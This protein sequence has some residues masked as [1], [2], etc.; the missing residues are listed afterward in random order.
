AAAPHKGRT[1]A[2]NRSRRGRTRMTGLCCHSREC[3]YRIHTSLIP[4]CFQEAADSLRVPLLREAEKVAGGRMG[5]G[6]QRRLE[7]G[8][9][10]RSCN[11]AGLRQQATPHPALRATFPSKL[12]KGGHAAI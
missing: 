10:R 5:C 3:G 6:K 7:A 1:A 11:S 4:L 12:G 8:S 2:G 9:R